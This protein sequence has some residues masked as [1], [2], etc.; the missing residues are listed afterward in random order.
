[1]HSLALVD[2]LFNKDSMKGPLTHWAS[3]PKSLPIGTL[4]TVS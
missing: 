3:R 2:P 1:M 4:D